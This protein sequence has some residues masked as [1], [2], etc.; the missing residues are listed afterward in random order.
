MCCHGEFSNNQIPNFVAICDEH[1][2]QIVMNVTKHIPGTKHPHN[3]RKQMAS[4]DFCC[5][6]GTLFLSEVGNGTAILEITA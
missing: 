6:L 2:F 5:I 1:Q 3:R 4:H